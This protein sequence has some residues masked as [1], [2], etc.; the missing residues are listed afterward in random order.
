MRVCVY[1]WECVCDF[2]EAGGLEVGDWRLGDWLWVWVMGL[3]LQIKQTKSCRQKKWGHGHHADP[4][5]L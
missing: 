2:I 3:G 4:V 1:V 5:W